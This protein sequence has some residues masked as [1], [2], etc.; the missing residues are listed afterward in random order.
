MSTKRTVCLLMNALTIVILQ[1]QRKH[2]T[3]IHQRIN[4]K[5]IFPA[6]QALNINQAT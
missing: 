4:H 6:D 2:A 1:I 5:A 3:I